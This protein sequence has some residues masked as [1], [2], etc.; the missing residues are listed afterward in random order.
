MITVDSAAA[1]PPP[2]LNDSEGISVPTKSDH[3]PS[4]E[5][6]EIDSGSAVQAK[7][8]GE[9]K[10]MAGRQKAV[11]KVINTPETCADGS[12]VETPMTKSINSKSSNKS[13]DSL[14]AEERE[15][16][17]RLI[18]SELVSVSEMRIYGDYIP[19]LRPTSEDLQELTDFMETDGPVPIKV[20]QLLSRFIEGRD[21][22]TGD[23]IECLKTII[24]SG[25]EE[26][27]KTV[28]FSRIPS[29]LADIA[30]PLD[31]RP[32]LPPGNDVTDVSFIRRTTVKD[33]ADFPEKFRSMVDVHRKME[34]ALKERMI[35]LFEMM[36]ELNGSGK[37][38]GKLERSLVSMK[39]RYA[40]LEER[41]KKEKE[42]LEI[43]LDAGKCYPRDPLSLWFVTY[44]EN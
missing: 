26:T 11:A 37:S 2:A 12:A 34:S 33:M 39:D 24:R 1:Q 29:I 30:E 8:E 35:H 32:K 21:Q 19:M 5:K 6:E 20:R 22:E 16:R 27:S 4:P 23:I 3:S 40:K 15:K 7:P 38:L 41:E 42:K 13:K 31:C 36:K 17:E 9:N 14:S 43:K 18:R 10:K 25:E 28:D 44:S